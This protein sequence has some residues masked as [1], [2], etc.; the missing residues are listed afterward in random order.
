MADNREV[1]ATTNTET[2][3]HEWDGIKELDTPMPRWWLWTFYATIVWGVIYTILMPAW[4]LINS[5]TPGLLGYSTRQDAERELV[6]HAEVNAPLDAALMEQAISKIAEDP[7]LLSYATAG[8]AAVFKAH[9]SQCHGAGA[10]GGVGYPNL[11]DDDWLWGGTAADIEQTITHGIR[12]EDDGDTRY[13]EMPAFGDILADEEI[14]QLVNYVRSMSGLDHDGE[15]AAPGET[16][17]VD[18]CA[19]CHGEDGKG[20]NEFGAPNLT[21]SIWLYGGDPE[22]LEETIRYSRYGIMPSFSYTGQL[23]ESDI[24]KVSI[25][26]HTL[27]GG[28]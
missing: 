15:L 25:Y 9:C 6:E 22:T 12:Y 20:L 4:P 3:G 11:L 16:L 5:A 19:S 24:R 18:N 13:S 28:Q 10:A 21:D 2:T 1:D 17:F 27:G 8:G 26:V 14:S 23:D 7:E